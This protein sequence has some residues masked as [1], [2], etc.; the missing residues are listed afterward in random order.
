MDSLDEVGAGAASLPQLINEVLSGGRAVAGWSARST[1]EGFVVAYDTHR[2]VLHKGTTL[3]GGPIPD[4]LGRAVRRTG[5][6]KSRPAP[7]RYGGSRAH[8]ESSFHRAVRWCFS[9]FPS[10]LWIGPRSAGLFAKRRRYGSKLRHGRCATSSAW[11]WRW[12]ASRDEFGAARPEKRQQSCDLK[13][14]SV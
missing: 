6:R 9:C 10:A 5:S 7:H 12:E 2:V 1:E 14:L 8:L 13:R 4:D 11:G 3:V